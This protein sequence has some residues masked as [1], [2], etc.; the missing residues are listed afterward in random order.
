MKKLALFLVVS[1]LPAWVLAHDHVLPHAH[2]GEVH[3]GTWVWPVLG[4]LVLLTIMIGVSSRTLRN[5]LQK[6]KIRS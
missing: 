5:R 4:M 3:G 1:A 2:E 6:S